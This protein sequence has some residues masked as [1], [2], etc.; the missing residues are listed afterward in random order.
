MAQ[1]FLSKITPSDVTGKANVVQFILG[2]GLRVDADLAQCP[3]DMLRSW[4]CMDCPRR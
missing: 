2:N 4:H 3:A 1:K